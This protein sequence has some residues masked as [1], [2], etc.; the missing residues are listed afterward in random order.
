MQTLQPLSRPEQPFGTSV[1]LPAALHDGGLAIVSRFGRRGACSLEVAVF[2]G[3]TLSSGTSVPGVPANAS[4]RAQV[5]LPPSDPCADGLEMIVETVMHNGT[6]SGLLL[7][8]TQV[9]L[10]QA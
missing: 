6:E 5:M 10:L 8:G 2:P 9:K 4:G 3:S 7:Q 1:D